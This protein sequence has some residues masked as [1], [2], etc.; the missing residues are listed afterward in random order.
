M[1]NNA[2][3]VPPCTWILRRPEVEARTGLSRS[4]I[5]LKIAQGIFPKP[6]SLGP[7]AV[8]WLATEVEAWL[9]RQVAVSRPAGA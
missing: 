8:G 4:T 9:Q 1:A 2:P 5:Y 3:H 7:R 6:I